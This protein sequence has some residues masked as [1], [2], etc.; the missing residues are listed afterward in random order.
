MD[1]TFD[2]IDDLANFTSAGTS[3][4]TVNTSKGLEY[5]EVE[6]LSELDSDFKNT[7]LGKLYI[8]SPENFM[9]IQ[10]IRFR[11]QLYFN[12]YFCNNTEITILKFDGEGKLVE[13]KHS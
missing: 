2:I 1:E 5:I 6:N 4:I 8:E 12:C 9:K 13:E 7:D 11:N 3:Q 10:K